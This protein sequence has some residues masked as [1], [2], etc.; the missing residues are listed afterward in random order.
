MSYNLLAKNICCSW[1]ELVSYLIRCW[2]TSFSIKASFFLSFFPLLSYITAS[3][4]GHQAEADVSVRPGEECG[5]APHW[6]VDAGQ[7]L[8]RHCGGLEPRDTGQLHIP[9]ITYHIPS[10][11]F[12]IIR[13]K[14]CLYNVN[15]V[16]ILHVQTMVKTFELCDLPVRVAKFVARKHWIIAGSVSI[17]TQ[18]EHWRFNQPTA[19][20]VCVFVFSLGPN[21]LVN[22]S[23]C[24]QDDMLIRVFNYN[25]LDRV[26]MF[27]A[28][29][30]YIRCVAVHPTQPYILS[31]SGRKR[32]TYAHTNT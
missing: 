10:S 26:H 28:H 7:P 20:P 5:S 24:P 30:D 9:L 19:R 6:A 8:Q 14:A 31:S 21:A 4:V 18:L 17:V 12:W 27:E 15:L 25:T 32:T 3:A 16:W 23:V 13:W 2:F 11:E 1:E 22:L 29:S